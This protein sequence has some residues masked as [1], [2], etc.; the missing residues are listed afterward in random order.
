MNISCKYGLLSQE[1]ITELFSFNGGV[2]KDEIEIRGFVICGSKNPYNQE[3][4]FLFDY[5]GERVSFPTKVKGADLQNISLLKNEQEKLEKT[6]SLYI[7]NIKL[8]RDQLEG[9]SK[10][11]N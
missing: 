6:R 8:L 2:L 7:E 1:Q 3:L 11:N 5:N 9:M 4:E 10:F